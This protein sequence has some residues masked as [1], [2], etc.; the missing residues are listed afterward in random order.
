MQACPRGK[1][2]GN[3][4][5]YTLP[6]LGCLVES[7]QE[8]SHAQGPCAC[9]VRCILVSCICKMLPAAAPPLRGL[10]C[11]QLLGFGANLRT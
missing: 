2:A 9:C 6:L 11:L 3:N 7:K 1:N 8:I 4:N 5:Q 10:A